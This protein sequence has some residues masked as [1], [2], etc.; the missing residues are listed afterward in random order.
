MNIFLFT[1][2]ILLVIIVLRT[3][4]DGR[5]SRKLQYAVWLILPVCVLLFYFFNIPIVVRNQNTSAPK[6]QYLNIQNNA[7]SFREIHNIQAVEITN[8]EDS[9][10]SSATYSI[11]ESDVAPEINVATTVAKSNKSVK[12]LSINFTKLSKTIWVVGMF[13]IAVVIVIR[14]IFFT[15]KTYKNRELYEVLENGRLKIYHLRT[16]NIPFLFGTSIYIPETMS[17]DMEGYNSIMCHEYCHYLLGDNLWVII[18]YVFIVA[19]WFNPLAW[20]ALKLIQKDDEMAVDEKVIETLGD[21]CKETYGSILIKIAA[22][23]QKRRLFLTPS[24]SFVGKNKSFLKKRISTIVN[25]TKKSIAATL[26][27]T[28]VLIALVSCSMFKTKV[29]NATEIVSADS[30]WYNCEVTKLEFGDKEYSYRGTES[31]FIE[32][33]VG[34]VSLWVASGNDSFDYYVV[35]IDLEGNIKSSQLVTPEYFGIND[36]MFYEMINVSYRDGA[37]ILVMAIVDP[38]T[39]IR[40]VAAY[41][42]ETKK[43][44]DISY[45]ADKITDGSSIK[46][47]G[48]VNGYDYLIEENYG[49]YTYSTIR[50]G[51][52]G[53]Y[54][55]GFDLFSIIHDSCNVSAP[56]IVND[57]LDFIVNGNICVEID[58]E[59]LT[60]K[61]TTWPYTAGNVFIGDEGQI[62]FAKENGIYC[63][64]ELVVPYNCSY[65]NEFDLWQA[66]FVD[67]ENGKFTML[68]RDKVYVFDKA[69]TNPNAGKEI[70]RVGILDYSDSFIM[71]ALSDFNKANDKYFAQAVHYN[72]EFTSEDYEVFSEGSDFDEIQMINSK[73]EGMINSLISDL[74]GGS[75]PDVIIGSDMFQQLNDDR[76]LIDMSSFIADDLKDMEL[77]D[78][79]I[80]AARFNDKLYQFPLS[81]GIRG[82]VTDKENVKSDAGFTYD[83]Y[84]EFLYGPCNGNNPIFSSTQTV[85]LLECLENNSASFIDKNGN[86]DF[87]NEEFYALAEF[88]KE[89]VPEETKSSFYS[90][91]AN[92][93]AYYNNYIVSYSTDMGFGD[94][95]IYG[96]PSV[97]GCGPSI[98]IQR[99]IAI[100]SVAS[101]EDAAKEFVSFTLR[102]PGILERSDMNTIS[103][104]ATRSGAQK[105]YDEYMDYYNGLLD[106]YSETE[107]LSYGIYKC[108]ENSID[109]YIDTLKNASRIVS[110]NPNIQLIVNEE[111][112]AYFLGDKSIEEV[113]KIIEDRAQTV[114]DER[115]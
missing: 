10:Q 30:L 79:V 103:V 53:E 36:Y 92:P 82:I 74:D 99:F 46:F 44:I 107:L 78:N 90:V 86:A 98:D 22:A 50:L 47:F 25:G 19:M 3:L 21:E 114:I 38:E 9:L 20:I 39:Y 2:I 11:D 27:V 94:V 31:G 70:I 1:S 62:Y 101:N 100:A 5:I 51:K 58:P 91:E 83:E 18:K 57:K 15:I 110:L 93:V 33:D 8:K 12:P 55:K 84:K 68:S 76:Y 56:I 73:K 41:N 108:D 75:G 14:N 13:V 45:L 89:N 97:D 59:D 52:D 88:T 42:L 65:A 63:D 16:T 29:R 69:D 87:T 64:D 115:N 95:G 104:E 61:T 54:L 66:S 34:Y 77:F 113:A 85:F 112:R 109:I 35:E 24:M 28:I 105:F 49:V 67:V 80:D 37:P 32:S 7:D 43:K 48:S 40:E 96:T 60:T 102:N 17:R 81:F 106:E 71:G 6:V 26:A 23:N 4:L 111:I 72:Y